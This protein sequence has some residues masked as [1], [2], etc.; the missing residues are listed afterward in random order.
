MIFK[1]FKNPL[2]I[3]SFRS[4]VPSFGV[5]SHEKVEKKGEGKGKVGKFLIEFWEVLFYV[6]QLY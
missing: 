3:K 1:N 5:L 6:I 2:L 4:Q